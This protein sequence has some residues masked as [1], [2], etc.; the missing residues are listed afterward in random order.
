MASL[1]DTCFLTCCPFHCHHRRLRHPGAGH[2]PPR[3]PCPPGWCC[4]TVAVRRARHPGRDP[5]QQTMMKRHPHFEWFSLC[6]SRACLGKM[7]TISGMYKTG[8]IKKAAFSFC[9]TTSRLRR[10]APSEYCAKPSPTFPPEVRAGSD[11]RKTHLF[12]S[13][14]LCL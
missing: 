5:L 8:F 13:V 1:K 6:L 10:L 3:P 7:T 2:A 9:R 12:F 14:S 4:G 11:L